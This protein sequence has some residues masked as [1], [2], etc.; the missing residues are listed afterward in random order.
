M[1]TFGENLR[2]CRKE[3]GLTQ[4]QLGDRLS[5]SKE[6]IS[7]YERGKL[8]PKIETVKRFADALSVEMD[9]LEHI[10]LGGISNG[11]YKNKHDKQRGNRGVAGI[12]HQPWTSEEDG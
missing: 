8:H 12:C 9:A 2:K 7:Q 10:R 3:A 5:C 6:L 4:Q 11:R 1:A